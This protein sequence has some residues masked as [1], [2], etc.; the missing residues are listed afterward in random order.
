MW[1][2]PVPYMR[3]PHSHETHAAQIL[4]DPVKLEFFERKPPLL[5]RSIGSI[6]TY[7]WRKAVGVRCEGGPTSVRDLFLFFFVST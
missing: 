3:V 4:T 6:V 5:R 7:A 1:I 2:L